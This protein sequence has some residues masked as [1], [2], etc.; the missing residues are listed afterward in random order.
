[1]QSGKCCVVCKLIGLLVIIGAINWGLVGAFKTDLVVMLLGSIP[2]AVRI[3]YIL[4][5]LAGLMKLV[6]C[7]KP[8]PCCAK[9]GDCSTPAAK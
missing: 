3:V 6:S 8:C 2:K 1:M 4:V 9:T 5:G 7:F